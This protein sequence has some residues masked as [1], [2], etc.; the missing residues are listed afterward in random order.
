MRGKI[1][2]TLLKNAKNAKNGHHSIEST[3]LSQSGTVKG[4]VEQ[5]QY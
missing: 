2:R 3:L 5:S 1:F 4:F